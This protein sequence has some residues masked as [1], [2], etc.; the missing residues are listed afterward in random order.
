VGYVKDLSINIIVGFLR[1]T[2]NQASCNL[3]SP[4]IAIIELENK[5]HPKQSATSFGRS[6]ACEGSRLETV[7]V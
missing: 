1:R 2:L 3:I 4:T 7:E 5:G 6:K